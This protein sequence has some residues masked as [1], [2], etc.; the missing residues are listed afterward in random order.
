MIQNG[1]LVECDAMNDAASIGGIDDVDFLILCLDRHGI[2]GGIIGDVQDIAAMGIRGIVIGGDGDGEGHAVDLA[3]IVDEEKVAVFEFDEVGGGVGIGE[4][5][6]GSCAPGPA[7]ITG[8]GTD[9]PTVGFAEIVSSAAAISDQI[10]LI[11]LDGGG[12]EVS[13]AGFNAICF[14]PLPIAFDVTEEE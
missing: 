12:L 2:G 14:D 11:N 9:E 13:E 3:V 8:F 4:F 6:F 5:C 7:S 10:F 1:G